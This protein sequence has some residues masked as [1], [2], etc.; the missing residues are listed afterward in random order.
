MTRVLAVVP[1]AGQGQRLGIG[2]NKVFLDLCGRPVLAHTVERLA[3][4]ELI[5]DLCLVTTPAEAAEV[6]RIG[7]AYAR[8]MRL[9]LAMGGET[10]GDS[11]RAGI[12]AGFAA[13]LTD[14]DL[15]LIH[16][17]ARCLVDRAVLQDSLTA[18][19]R[20]G[21]G[22]AA[23]PVKDTIKQLSPGSNR[24]EVTPDR[25]LLRAVQTPQSFRAGLIRAAYRQAAAGGV[26]RQTDD[27]AVAEA[28]GLP[29]FLTAGSEQNLKITTPFDV[30]MATHLLGEK[31]AETGDKGKAN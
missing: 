30:Q 8:D 17:A 14:D 21:S 15:I 26:I 1:A 31:A 23:I 3:R 2:Y 25:D 7:L 10:R 11:V 4:S 27:A 12:E 6:Q 13:G 24:V 29:V 5:T 28:F 18:A 9:F 19:E 16:D 20:Q 22:V